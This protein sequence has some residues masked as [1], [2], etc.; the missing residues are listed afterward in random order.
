[1]EIFFILKKGVYFDML[2]KFVSLLEAANESPDA[3]ECGML[4]ILMVFVFS[5]LIDFISVLCMEVM[6]RY[7]FRHLKKIVKKYIDLCKNEPLDSFY[8]RYL[9][10]NIVDGVLYDYGYV[11]DSRKQV[12]I[13]KPNF[14]DKLIDFVKSFKKSKKL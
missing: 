5:S 7:R 6:H 14:I 9:R 13:R 1:M 10:S 4:I 8:A 12:Y 11:F 3:F 2:E